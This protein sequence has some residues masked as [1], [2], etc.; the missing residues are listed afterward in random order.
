MDKPHSQCAA[1][2]TDFKSVFCNQY[3][4]PTQVEAQLKYNIGIIFFI[5]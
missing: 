3:L 5:K 2:N 4:M 1:Q